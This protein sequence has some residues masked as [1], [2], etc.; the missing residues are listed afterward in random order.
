MRLVQRT[1]TN[2]FVRIHDIRAAVPQHMGHDIRAAVPQH[3]GH[4]LLTTSTAHVNPHHGL[5]K[6]FTFM[7]FI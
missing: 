4:E 5:K 7:N 3:M 2:R 1:Q 6:G